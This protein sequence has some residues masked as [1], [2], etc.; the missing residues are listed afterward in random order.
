MK[1]I[2]VLLMISMP[3]GLKAQGIK[4][5]TNLSWQQILV[6]ARQ[7]HKYIFVDCYASWCGPCK[8]MDKNVY[9]K[10]TVGNIINAAFI[11]LKVQCDTSK[12][13]NEEIK[14]RYA[15]ARQIV[16]NFHIRAYPTF[17]FFSPDGKLVHKG[18][19]YQGPKHFIALTEDAMNPEKQYF[20]LLN[21]YKSGK[22]DY[23]LLP[24]LAKMVKDFDDRALFSVITKDYIHNYLD[25]L[26]DSKFCTKTNFELLSNNIENLSSKDRAFSWVIHH[27]DKVDS[28]IQQKN[29]SSDLVNAIIYNEEV[30][31][32]LKIS[33]KSGIIPDWHSINESITEKFGTAKYLNKNIL[34]GKIAWYNFKK[35]WENL[36]RYDIQLIEEDDL[37]N[38][39]NNPR[40]REILNMNAWGIFQHSKDKHKL[41]KALS[42][43][44]LVVASINDSTTHADQFLD[45]KANL[46]YKLGRKREAIPLE[47]KAVQLSLGRKD[48]QETLQKMQAGKKTW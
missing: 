5:E 15:D 7:E 26:P 21:I 23:A 30:A 6:K 1:K 13:D 14:A 3:F 35:D 32:Q 45:T 42:W 40:N 31:P 47:T 10:D 4:F 27:S 46:L 38:D 34:N 8:E 28:V 18:E 37:I 24:V 48:T 17:L 29:F 16:T 11:S 43:M 36:F 22:M 19:G 39:P 2:I 20:T 33:E 25:Q 41:K 44:D 12:A 9:P